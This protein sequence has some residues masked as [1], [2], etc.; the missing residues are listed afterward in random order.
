[1]AHIYNGLLNRSVLK[2]LQALCEL[3]VHEDELY[4]I[5]RV[6]GK[7]SLYANVPDEPFLEPRILILKSKKAIDEYA[8][9]VRMKHI[10]RYIR[11]HNIS[12][13]FLLNEVISYVKR[14]GNFPKKANM[15]KLE[16]E[17]EAK[18]L[19][20]L[21]CNFHKMVTK[22]AL[23][24]EILI[25]VSDISKKRQADIDYDGEN[26]A[27]YEYAIDDFFIRYYRNR[28]TQYCIARVV[29]K[30]RKSI[31]IKFFYSDGKAMVCMDDV[32]YNPDD[33][34]FKKWL[35]KIHKA[36]IKEARRLGFDF[37]TE[38]DYKN[39]HV[40]KRNYYLDYLS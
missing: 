21:K 23:A 6:D 2:D 33:N 35:I 25:L 30:N 38:I 13:D 9:W 31:D 17:A 28:Y 15:I 37:V 16:K 14:N 36:F 11:V 4:N 19:A 12:K 32:S 5:L 34:S 18:R 3:V 7:V 27:K 22:Q 29:T 40:N 39:L 1:M 20:I 10:K 26:I 8:K 24:S